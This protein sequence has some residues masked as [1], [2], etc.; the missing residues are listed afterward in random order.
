MDSNIKNSVNYTL[1][2]K[3]KPLISFTLYEKEELILDL[4]VINK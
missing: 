1:R 2:S 3:D 4:G